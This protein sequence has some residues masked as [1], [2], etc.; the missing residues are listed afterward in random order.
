MNLYRLWRR[1]DPASRFVARRFA[2]KLL[3]LLAFAGAQAFGQYGFWRALLSLL[4][5]SGPL[6]I[7]L[8][9]AHRQRL[10]ASTLTYWDEALVFSLLAFTILQFV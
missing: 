8:A 10:D 2:L 5:L 7:G 3:I 6:S 9:F 4:L 1:L